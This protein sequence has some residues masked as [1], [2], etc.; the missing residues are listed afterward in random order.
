M[1]RQQEKHK[2]E[3]PETASREDNTDAGKI[4]V[5]ITF[6]VTFNKQSKCI[7]DPVD[8]SLLVELC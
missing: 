7:T 2:D 6:L 1:Q 3:R 5:S 8:C 4:H